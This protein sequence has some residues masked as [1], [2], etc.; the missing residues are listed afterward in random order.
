MAASRV[1]ICT[2]P[3]TVTVSSTPSGNDWWTSAS[4]PTEAMPS[5]LV[6]TAARY[7]LQC[8]RL[9]HHSV[10]P[11]GFAIL[12]RQDRHG[13]MFEPGQRLPSATANRREFR[14]SRR[15]G[16]RDRRVL[17]RHQRI[18]GYAA[19]PFVDLDVFG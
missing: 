14:A 2:S 18:E 15:Y 10:G 9:A 6:T 13:R 12:P 17:L 16:A 11:D 5:E 7:P 4:M 8:M 3:A 19:G 1:N